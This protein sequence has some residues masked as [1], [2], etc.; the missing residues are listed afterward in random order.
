MLIW[1]PGDP[2]AGPVELGH[3][4]VSVEAVAVL[5]DGTVVT[6]GKDGPLLMWDPVDPGADPVELGRHDGTTRACR[7]SR[8]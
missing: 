6:A 1:K 3:H 5:A 2:G 7:R 8:N 4:D